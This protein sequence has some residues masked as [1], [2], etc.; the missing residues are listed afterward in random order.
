MFFVGSPILDTHYHILGLHCGASTDGRSNIGIDISKVCP[1][2][3]PDSRVDPPPFHQ[4]Q[5]SLSLPSSSTSSTYN[6]R[7]QASLIQPESGY[8]NFQIPTENLDYTRWCTMA[9]AN[10][11][12]Q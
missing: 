2:L 1:W 3:N 7:Q 12:N 8:S 10:E 4:Q 9:K 5:Q 11:S 6:G